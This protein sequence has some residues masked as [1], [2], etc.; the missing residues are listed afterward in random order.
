MMNTSR[1]RQ[2]QDN[3]GRRRNPLEL[4]MNSGLGKLLG[5]IGAVPRREKGEESLLDLADALLSLRGRASGPAIASA[6]FDLYEASDLASRQAFLSDCSSAAATIWQNA[7][8][9]GPRVSR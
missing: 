8:S 9:P 4:L 1:S 2:A 7:E 5:R 6:F 3:P